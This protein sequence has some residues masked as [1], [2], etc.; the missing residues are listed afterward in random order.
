RRGRDPGTADELSCRGVRGPRPVRR[1]DRTPAAVVGRRGANPPRAG[2]QR[3][4][5]ENRG[6]R[7]RP[8]GHPPHGTRGERMTVRKHVVVIGGGVAGLATA[9]LLAHD[10]HDVEIVE[11]NDELGGRAGLWTNE[12]FRFDTGPSW[13]LM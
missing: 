7:R 3:G 8:A 6:R 1:A 9:A 5:G 13:W 12:G 2:S 11:K 10:G 4:Q